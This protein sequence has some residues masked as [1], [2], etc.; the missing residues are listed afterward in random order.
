MGARYKH[1]A[2][3]QFTLF[4]EQFAEAKRLLDSD[5]IARRRMA[6]VAIANL[7]EMLLSRRIRALYRYA[8]ETSFGPVRLFDRRE[9]AKLNSDFG[10]R[11]SV[12]Q[13]APTDGLLST[14][15]TPVLDALDAAIFRV[16]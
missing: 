11:V 14:I 2:D 15:L 16:A 6:L 7:A 12:A 3:A 5:S 13:W 4:V 10:A 9:R 1:D 8:E